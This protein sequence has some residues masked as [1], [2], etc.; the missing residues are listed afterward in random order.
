MVNLLCT[1]NTV[2]TPPPSLTNTIIPP[3]LPGKI[4]WFRACIVWFQDLLDKLHDQN[5][6]VSLK[7]VMTVTTKYGVTKMSIKRGMEFLISRSCSNTLIVT[8]L[9]QNAL[10]F[11]FKLSVKI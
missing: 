3:P 9:L 8:L 2:Q 11:F 10:G 6:L 7:T 5:S 1:K 4:F